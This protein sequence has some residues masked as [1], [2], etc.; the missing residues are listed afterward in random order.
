MSDTKR[1]EEGAG[2]EEIAVREEKYFDLDI[3][4]DSSFTSGEWRI[5]V[6]RDSG[7]SISDGASIEV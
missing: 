5:N 3:V 1:P 6:L 4:K 2:Q 7:I